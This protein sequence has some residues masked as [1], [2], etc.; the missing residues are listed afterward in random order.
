MLK[1]SSFHKTTP[2]YN[3]HCFVYM[4]MYYMTVCWF[5]YNNSPPPLSRA[6]YSFNFTPDYPGKWITRANNVTLSCFFQITPLSL[7]HMTVPMLT[8]A[9]SHCLH[10]LVESVEVIRLLLSVCMHYCHLEWCLDN[11]QTVPSLPSTDLCSTLAPLTDFQRQITTG[12][13]VRER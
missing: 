3:L 6:V 13:T 11:G 8:I 1:T 2:V 12:S 9:R 4:Y 7:V 10:S 5:S